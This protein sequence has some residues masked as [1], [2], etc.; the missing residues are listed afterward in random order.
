LLVLGGLYAARS[1]VRIGTWHDEETFFRTAAAQSPRSVY[2]QW[3]L[4]ACCSSA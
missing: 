2:V 1:F 4:G 3:G